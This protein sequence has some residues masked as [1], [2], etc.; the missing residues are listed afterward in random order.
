MDRQWVLLYSKRQ[1]AWHIETLAEY[2]QKPA[3][4]YE[5]I[6]RCNSYDEAKAKARTVRQSEKVIR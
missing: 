3:N 2:Q 4:G 1:N 5:I 6:S